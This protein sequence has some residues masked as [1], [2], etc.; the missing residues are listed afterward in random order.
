[1]T[2]RS[3][4]ALN[5]T[6]LPFSTNTISRNTHSHQSSPNVYLILFLFYVP[7]VLLQIKTDNILILCYDR[8]GSLGLHFLFNRMIMLS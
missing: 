7:Q 6:L 5:I 3:N 1:M 2:F 8:I 4:M